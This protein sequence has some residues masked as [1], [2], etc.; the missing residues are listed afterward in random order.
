MSA[1]QP[2]AGRR[3]GS[4]RHVLVVED[5]TLI[6]T[7]LA[8]ELEDAGFT[9]TEAGSGDEAFA[10]L[11]DSVKADLVVTDV[12]MPGT[13]DGLQL[14]AWLRDRYPATR[15][16]VMSGFVHESVTSIAETYDAFVRKPF[17]P[18]AVVRIAIGLLDGD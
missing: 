9:V 15:I 16:I 4:P 7:L 1:V 8:M 6:R 12:R 17:D 3:P 14:A 13:R 10:M 18:A 2:A 5:E 11:E